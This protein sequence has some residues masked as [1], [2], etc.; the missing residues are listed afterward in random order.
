VEDTAALAVRFDDG[1]IGSL[2]VTYTTD[3][4]TD[5]LFFGLRGTLGWLNWDR[6][7]PEIEVRSTHPSWGSGQTR[8][9]RF[10]PDPVDGYAG[11]VGMTALRRFI[12][13]I[14]EGATPVFTPD[15]S[16]RVLEVLDAAQESQRTGRRV[17]VAHER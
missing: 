9:T 10:T 2:H 6:S 11:S 8:V 5:Q 14:R 17:G 12:A 16:L 1:K 7:G 3:R 15:D 13:S 4:A